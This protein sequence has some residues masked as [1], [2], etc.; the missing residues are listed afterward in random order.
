MAKGRLHAAYLAI[1]KLVD[2]YFPAVGRVEE[3]VIE[4][5]NRNATKKNVERLMQKKVYGIRAKL[6]RLRRTIAPMRDLLYRIIN[7]QRIEGIERELVYFTDI[8]HHLLKLMEMVE[9][10]R[11]MTSDIRDSYLSLN[12]YRMNGIM[13]T[14]TVITTIFMPL[15]FIAGVYGMNFKKNIPELNWHYGYF[16][17]L[18]LMF[19]VGGGLYLWFRKKR[20]VRL[21]PSV[22]QLQFERS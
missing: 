5:E 2:P 14:L 6:L 9:S 12:S 16:A 21:A 17:A 19:A 22:G 8:Y 3:A 15:T 1:D 13:K 7:S 11:E 18:G 10:A 20:L 4:I